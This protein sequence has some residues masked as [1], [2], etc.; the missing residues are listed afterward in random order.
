[1][2][3]TTL[4]PG[5]RLPAEEAEGFD[6]IATALSM[7]PRQVEEYFVAARSVAADIFAQPTLRARIVKCTPAE[8]GCVETVIRDFGL[9]AFRRPLNT[10]ESAT[11][12]AKYEAARALG[13]DAAGALEHVVH[14]MLA[15]PQFLYRIE[16]DADLT[17]SAP[18]PVD[19]YELASRLSYALWSTMPDE[20]LFAAASG[21]GLVEPTAL[22]AEVERMLADPKAEMLVTNFAAQWFGGRRLAEHVASPTTYP[23]YGAELA[24]SMQREMDL[25]FAEFLTGDRPYSEFLTAD[26]NFVDAPLAA[27][28]GMSPPSGTG[29]QR[30]VETGDARVGFLGLAGFLTHTSRETRSSPIIRGKWILDAIWCTPLQVPA[31]LVIEALEEPTEG[32]P[33]TVREQMAAHRVSP[34]CSGC[35]DLIDPIGLALENFDAVG[36]YRGVYENGLA[37]DTK[38]KMPDGTMIEGLAS[39]APALA[40]NPRFLGCAATKFGTYALGASL[41]G[42]NQEQILASWQAGNPT[43][44]NL[45]KHVISHDSFRFRRAEGP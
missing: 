10:A 5:A 2:T 30:V 31:T 16:F 12:L 42:A 28:Y 4:R 34:A 29:S 3:G 7:S 18:H 14:V 19:G 32:P 13:I 36:R 38:G 45:I 15:S 44:R 25:Y 27:L 43:L 26:F 11:L 35:H 39:L 20:Q 6:N 24:A 21:A 22:L 8:A 40:A 23:A 41:P 17:N 37:I 33:T 9:R 1:M